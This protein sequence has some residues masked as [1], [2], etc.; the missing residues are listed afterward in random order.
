MIDLGG[1]SITQRTQLD[2]ILV[3]VIYSIVI[4]SLGLYVKRKGSEGSKLSHFLTGGGGLNGFEVAMISMTFGLAGGTMVSGPGLSYGVGFISIIAIYAGLI[5]AFATFGN[6]GKKIS[7]VGRRLKAS[8]II[9]MLHHRFQSK[10]LACVLGLGMVL[11][12]IPKVASQLMVAAKLFSAMTGSNSY[13]IG[14]LIATSAT[15][16]YTLSGGLKS[17][18]K[19]CVL[20]GLL[21]IGVVLVLVFREYSM[22]FERFGS[23]QGAYEYVASIKPEL[24]LANT[25]QPMYTFGMAMVYG[26]A[27]FAQP[28]AVHT[29]LTYN[30]PKAFAR[31]M[32]ISVLCGSFIQFG[33]SGSSVLT[34]A[35]NPNLSQPDYAVMYLSTEMLS[36]VFVGFTIIACFAAVQSTVSGLLLVTAASICKDVYKECFHPDASEKTVSRINAAALVL[37]SVLAV[38]IGLYPTTFTQLLNT[39]SGA[40]ID[41]VFIMPLMFGLYWKRATEQGAIW[42]VGGGLATY[43]AGYMLQRFVPSFWTGVLGNIHPIVPGLIVS[44]LLMIFVSRRTRKV[45]LGVCEVWFSPDYDE[46]FCQEYD[47]R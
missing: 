3:V 45:P 17:I 4:V 22:I 31:A 2:I 7:I 20:Q 44:A 11:F 32:V 25:W 16:I 43:L 28:G 35:L 24:L 46:R 15:V 40:G 23:V 29:A 34:F 39:F 10:R 47:L 9:Q 14:L 26:W 42:S 37:I 38:V 1:F 19:V 21:M 41:I 27:S 5:G 30:S 33:L 13:L 8:T 18:S 6:C 36:G 12:V